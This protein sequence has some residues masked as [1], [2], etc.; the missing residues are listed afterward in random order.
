MLAPGNLPSGGISVPWY[1]SSSH[2][3]PCP[4]QPS[5]ARGGRDRCAGCPPGQPVKDMR[6]P[7]ARSQSA[8]GSPGATAN[9]REVGLAPQPACSPLAPHPLAQT[10]ASQISKVGVWVPQRVTLPSFGLH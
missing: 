6:A 4:A 10:L 3:Q 1:T 8:R 2:P 9:Q 5:G 7:Q